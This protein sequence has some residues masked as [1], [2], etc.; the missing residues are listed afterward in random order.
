ME[1]LLTGEL[2][3]SAGEASKRAAGLIEQL[4]SVSQPTSGIDAAELAKTALRTFA[5]PELA[6]DRESL[7][8]EIPVFG[9]IAGDENR[10]VTGRAD[11]VR[12][13]DGR[14]HI[15]FDWKSDI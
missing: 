15:V 13:K 1:E 4:A 8:A 7:V 11:A 14:P 12:Y 5:L 10:L 9:R 2:Q 6:L 3:N